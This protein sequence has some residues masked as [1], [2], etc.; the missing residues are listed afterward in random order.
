MT[1]FLVT[2]SAGLIGSQIIKDLVKQ[3]YEIYSC[4]NNSKPK[5]GILTFLDLTNS[6]NIENTLNN[7]QPDVIIHLA[8]ITNVDQCEAD[9][10]M[11]M[12]IN[13]KATELLSRQAEKHNSF[14]IYVSTDYVFDGTQGMRKELDS[15]NPL[16]SYGKSK[17]EGERAVQNSKSNWC[18]ARTSAPFGVHPTKKS[19][20]LWV[21]ENLKSKNKIH[22]L[23]DQFTSPTYVPNLSKM[24]IEIATRQLVG[25]IHVAGA[26]R[27]SRFNFAKQIAST[28]KLDDQFINPTTLK[29]MKWNKTRPRDSSLDVS[30]ASH[31]LNEKPQ[32]L[33]N[34][35]QKFVEEI[36][37]II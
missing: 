12:K 4:Y 32:K 17:L 20:P 2:G 24:L 34:T 14:F 13:A 26:T 36:H 28:L 37:E 15:V 8:A 5:Y 1:K 6:T 21:A 35:T 31:I 25:I 30:K 27:I 16:G 11:A 19:F 7:I 18:I 23:T 33:D 3:N 9:Q 22:V 29:E 10:E